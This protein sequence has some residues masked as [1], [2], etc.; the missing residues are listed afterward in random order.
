MTNNSSNTSKM[1]LAFNRNKRLAGVFASQRAVAML[2]GISPTTARQACDGNIIST[3]NFYLRNLAD[4][5]EIDFAT[6]I[7]VLTLKEYDTLT[8]DKRKVYPNRSMQRKSLKLKY[9]MGMTPEKLK[10]LK[11]QNDEDSSSN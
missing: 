9:N 8:G 11:T 3:R 10:R 5:I 7:G 1:V 4:D 2:L 6:E